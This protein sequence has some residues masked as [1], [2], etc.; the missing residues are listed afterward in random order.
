M[1]PDSSSRS[2]E[3]TVGVNLMF[4]STRSIFNDGVPNANLEINK[5]QVEFSKWTN[6]V[7]NLPRMLGASP[8]TNV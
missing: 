7:T 3:E 1:R 8:F 2:R 4:L 5:H 6:D